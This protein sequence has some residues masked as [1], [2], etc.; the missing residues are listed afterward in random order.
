MYNILLLAGNVYSLTTDRTNNDTAADGD[1]DIS[2]NPSALDLIIRVEG[3]GKATISQDAALVDD[4]VLE[5]HEATVRIENLILTG[6]SNVGGG[7]GLLNNGTIHMTASQVSG[8]S[9]S[10]DGGGIYNSNV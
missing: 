5:N 2:D 3:D 7:G 6:G 8:N 4:R 10:W 1:L 9:V